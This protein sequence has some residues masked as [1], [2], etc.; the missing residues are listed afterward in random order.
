MRYY[1]PNAFLSLAST[2]SYGERNCFLLRFFIDSLLI[3]YFL[4]IYF[5]YFLSFIK[6]LFLPL[7]F[8]TL[9]SFLIIFYYFSFSFSRV[10][11]IFYTY[12]FAAFH[13]FGFNFILAIL[14]VLFLSFISTF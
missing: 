14:S 10:S 4:L 5:I 9:F 6:F 11:I 1:C 13:F 2:F 8:F 12:F 3:S 7:S